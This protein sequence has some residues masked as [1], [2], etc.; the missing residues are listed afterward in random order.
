MCI[1]DDTESCGCS[2]TPSNFLSVM[3]SAPLR[4]NF[5]HLQANTRYC[6]QSIGIYRVIQRLKTTPEVTRGES[7]SIMTDGKEHPVSHFMHKFN[8]SLL[9]RT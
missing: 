1:N 2:D 5:P 4:F 7:I 6:M 8:H 3:N 9:N